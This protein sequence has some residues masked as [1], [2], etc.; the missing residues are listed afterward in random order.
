MELQ[1]GEI[2]SSN[3]YGDMEV[4]E[5]I[6]SKNVYVRFIETGYVTCTQ[7]GHIRLG[8]VKDLF[9]P[10]VWGVG[11][12]GVGRYTWGSKGKETKVY[13]TWKNMLNRCYNPDYH[14]KYPTYIGC[15]VTKDWHNFQVFAEWFDEHYIEGYHL[16][17]DIKDSGNKVY[18][19]ETCI[20]VTQSDNIEKACAVSGVFRSPEG[21]RVEVYNLSAF[22]R[23]NGLIQSKL[24][25]VN[26]GKQTQH[27]GW[28]LWVENYVPPK[29]VVLATFK[30]PTGNLVEVTN[31]SALAREHELD[32]SALAKL[33]NGKQKTHK[34]WTLYK[35]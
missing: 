13:T 14:K 23:E 7:A 32:P 25:N 28:T 15:T 22:S 12:L 30:G 17:K 8:K 31:L 1:L 10:S 18:G 2:Y 29:E 16:D 27:K 19:P 24:S 5:Y 33:K 35:E 9:H 26:N 34:G 3:N 6:N 21:I 4:V 20:F 11:Y